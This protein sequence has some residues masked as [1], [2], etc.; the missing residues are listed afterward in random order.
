MDLKLSGKSVIVTGASQGIGAGLAEAFAREGCHVFLISR[1]SDD[2][3][4]VAARLQRVTGAAIPWLALD[5]AEAGAA[6]QVFRW[7]PDADILINNAGAIPG[8]TIDLVDE[9][10]WRAAW[11]LKV[12][13]YI[14]LSRLYFARMRARRDGVILNIIGAA[15]EMADP[16][17]IAGTSGNAALIAFTQAL[18]STS[19][20][21]GVRV[22]GINPGPVGTERL[23]RQLKRRAAA[24]LGDDARWG[25]FYGSFPAGRAALVEEITAAA[26]FLTSPLS[27]YTSGTTLTIDGGFSK[28]RTR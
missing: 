6:E 2:L 3:A 23:V 12:Y 9:A 22:L 15:G 8:G 1:S 27:G 18:G 5:L 4:A 19:L 28:R 14:G 20:A 26:L 7:C 16:D 24:T 10:V 11:D 21:Q 17:Y 13:A 25:E